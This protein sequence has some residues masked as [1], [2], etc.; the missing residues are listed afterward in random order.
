[1][2]AMPLPCKLLVCRERFRLVP[3]W[4]VSSFTRTCAGHAI[5][6]SHSLY[7][8]SDCLIVGGQQLSIFSSEHAT[9]PL[10]VDSFCRVFLPQHTPFM[11]RTVGQRYGVS[12]RH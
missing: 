9:Q 12:S 3:K 11:L 4:T 1:M 6:A 10:L 5:R 7:C 8:Q 2:L